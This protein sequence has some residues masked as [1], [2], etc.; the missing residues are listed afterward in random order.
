[1]PKSVFPGEPRRPPQFAINTKLL[2]FVWAYSG[3]VF[4]VA[5]VVARVMSADPRLLFPIAAIALAGGVIGTFVAL[6]DTAAQNKN[7]WLS[8]RKNGRNRRNRFNA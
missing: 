7:Q 2:W 4:F 8:G 1:M 3:L 5:I 6:E